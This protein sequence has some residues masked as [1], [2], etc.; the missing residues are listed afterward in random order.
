MSAT[1]N[2]KKPSKVEEQVNQEVNNP[3]PSTDSTTDQI[4]DHSAQ[5]YL[6]I[7]NDEQYVAEIKSKKPLDP[8]FVK[9]M[10]KV[11]SGE[12]K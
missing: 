2:N 12:I 9:F 7:W 11:Q 5:A 1:E 4:V 10:T 3:E 8:N 6:D